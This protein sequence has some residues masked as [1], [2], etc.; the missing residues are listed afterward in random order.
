MSTEQ[1]TILFVPGAWHFPAGFDGVR[2]LLKPLGYATEAVTLPSIGAEPPTKTLADDSAHTRATIEKLVDA[3]KKVVVVTHSYGGVVGS[4]AV[5]DLGFAQRKAAS[6]EG[7]VI[8]F[9]YLSAFAL[10]KGMNFK[11]DYVT[12]NTP[13]EIAQLSHTSATVFSGKSTHEPWHHMPCTYI[14]CEEDKAIPLIVQQGITGSIG[15]SIT[16]FSIKAS[17]SPFLSVPDKLV[18][19]IKLAAK[20]GLEK[21]S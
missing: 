12:P 16:T 14:Y 4:C 3:G 7:G 6:K 21:S 10:P 18:E 5:E 13:E 19:G 15:S 2:E 17:H 11:G 9:V 20:V 8:N 1:P